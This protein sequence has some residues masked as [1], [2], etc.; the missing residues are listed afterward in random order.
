LL[1]IPYD[2]AVK[3]DPN[4]SKSSKAHMKY[5]KKGNQ[6]EETRKYTL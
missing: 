1:K 6:E 3:M 4:G 5:S 2:I